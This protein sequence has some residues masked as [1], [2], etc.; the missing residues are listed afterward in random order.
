MKTRVILVLVILELLL[1]GMWW[2]L[3]QM[4]A[5]DP[6]SVTPDF[7]KT[8]GETMGMAMGALLGFGV[9]MVFVAARNDRKARGR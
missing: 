4:G 7:Q 8:L 5:S 2:F 3:A 6:S 9:L 1:A